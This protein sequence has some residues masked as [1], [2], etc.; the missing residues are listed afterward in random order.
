MEIASVRSMVDVSM[1]DRLGSAE[2]AMPPVPK[3]T[4]FTSFAD[5]RHKKIKWQFSAMLETELAMIM[6]SP[7]SLLVASDSAS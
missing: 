2:S 7:L 3:I 4:S 5:G 6:L 1:I